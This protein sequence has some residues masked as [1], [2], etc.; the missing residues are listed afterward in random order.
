MFSLRHTAL[1]SLAM[2]AVPQTLSAEEPIPA[3]DRTASEQKAYE[4]SARSDRSDNGYQDSRVSAK[5]VLRNRAGQETWRDFSF[6]TLERTGEDVG[7]KSLIVFRSPRDVEGTALLSHAKILEPDDQW[8]FLPAL[9]RVKRISSANKSGAFVGSEFSFEDFTI[10]ELNKFTYDYV[11][12][13]TI[14]GV[15]MDVVDRFPRYERSGYTKQRVWID[16]DIFQTH[17]VEFYDRKDELLKILR[18]DDYRDYDGVWRAHSL[19]MENV[20]SGKITILDYGDFSFGN[21][22]NDN[23]FQQGALAR[24]R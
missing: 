6:S 19:S 22:M 13:E 21:G 5:M 3:Q 1:A 24:L 4:I 17:K 23:D 15:T 7:D 9:K 8:L 10:T 20:Q 14:D 12:E 18:L 16:Q 2:L 11:G